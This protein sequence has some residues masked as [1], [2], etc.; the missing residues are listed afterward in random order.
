[1]TLRLKF[2]EGS[3]GKAPANYTLSGSGVTVFLFE[4]IKA[5][6][7]YLNIDLLKKGDDSTSDV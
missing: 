3:A 5:E 4:P 1:M 2:A 7:T 6:S